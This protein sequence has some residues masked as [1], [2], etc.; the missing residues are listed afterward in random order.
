MTQQSGPTLRDINQRLQHAGLAQIPRSRLKEIISPQIRERFLRSVYLAH[1]DAR[2]KHFVTQV[3]EAGGL[4]VPRAELQPPAANEQQPLSA[5]P[6]AHDPESSPAGEWGVSYHVYGSKAALCFNCDETKGKTPT[7][8][9][10]AATLISPKNYDWKNK[11]RIQL[12]KQ[13][14]PVVAAVM[15]GVKQKCEFK[16]HGKDNDKGF[17]MERQEGGKLFVSV[18][19]KG[20]PVK[21][22]PVFQPD[23]LW[24]SAL[25]VSQIQKGCDGLDTSGV[26]AIVRITQSS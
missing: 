23:L 22:V 18:F 20:L 8:S 2:A 9:L 25:F 7:I 26:I 15:L 16:N 24:V 3:L 13:E 11:I 19:A 12:T 4:A 6:G 14:L 5:A 10:D 21:A 17:S 1:Q